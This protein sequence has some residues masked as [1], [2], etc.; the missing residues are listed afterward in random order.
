MKDRILLRTNLMVCLVILA[1]FLLTAI[2]SYRLNYQ[3]SLKSIEQVSSLSAEGIY[4]Q[5]NNILSK[6]VNVSLTM[7]NDSLLKDLLLQEADRRDDPA[8]I[9]TI[10]QYLLGYQEKYGYDSVFLVSAASARYYNFNGLD[11]VL[12]P[13]DPENFWYYNVLLPSDEEYATNVD[14]DEVANA[15]NAI[16]LFVNC[17]IYGDGGGLLGV[18]GVGVRIDQ[19]QQILQNYQNDFSVN[20]Y[21]VDEAGSIEL[22][23]EI[24][25]YDHV[26]LF[27]TDDGVDADAKQDVLSW[28][29]DSLPLSFWEMDS[30]GRKQD[31]IVTRYLPEIGWHLVAERDTRELVQALNRQVVVTVSIILLIIG[32][33]LLIITRVIRLFNRQIV[34]LER[35][36]EQER[37]SMFEKATEQMFE[38]IYELDITHNRPANQVTEQYFESLG[39]P[40]G[41]PFDQALAIIAQKQIKPEFQQGYIQT[42][43]PPNVLEA[44]RQGVDSLSYDFMITDSAGGYYWMRITARLLLSESDGALHM[45]TYRQNIDAV[46]RREQKM[47]ELART[48][49]MTGLLNKAAIQRAVEERLLQEPERLFAFLIFDIDHFKDANDFFGHAYGD[50]VIQAFT[51]TLRDYLQQDALLGRVGG[52][53]FVAF[54]PAPD[55]AWAA[56]KARELNQALNCEHVEGDSRWHMSASIGVAFAPT[57]GVGFE[58]LYQRADTALYETKKRGRGSFTLFRSIQ[59]EKDGPKK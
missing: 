11:R 10:R 58:T 31:Y 17:K 40:A 1:G 41:T 42:F 19:L 5:M 27:D 52:D 39:A 18:V 43:S 51:G 46:M 57:D 54:L 3:A 6:P 33:I 47:Q 13:G 28:K 26:S 36:C 7:A 16:T 55:E 49:E 48:D 22:S 44:F 50:K 38:D 20:T 45:L 15:E 53:E 30:K 29:E 25:G 4:Y 56:E 32:V 8:Y 24:T 34:A 21:F 12:K 23:A 2:F 9:E 37:K 35:A 14:N 59:Q